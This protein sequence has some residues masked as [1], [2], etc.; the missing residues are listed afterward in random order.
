MTFIYSQFLLQPNIDSIFNASVIK[1]FCL[2]GYASSVI[3]C[4]INSSKKTRQFVPYYN[5]NKYNVEIRLTHSKSFWSQS[6]KYSIAGYT[7]QSENA[8]LL[9][10]T[11]MVNSPLKVKSKFLLSLKS[12]IKNI[13]RLHWEFRQIELPRLN[14]LKMDKM[15]IKKNYLV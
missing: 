14:R 11:L 6:S 13:L 3:F 7:T 2:Y 5:E 15:I 10:F 12:V 4:L 8:S 9:F 1:N